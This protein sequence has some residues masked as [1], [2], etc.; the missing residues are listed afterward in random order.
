MIK[1]YLKIFLTDRLKINI[2][3][4][5]ALWD[6][7]SSWNLFPLSYHFSCLCH[8]RMKLYSGRWTNWW[9]IVQLLTETDLLTIHKTLIVPKRK[10][11]AFEKLLTHIIPHYCI[12]FTGN[13]WNVAKVFLRKNA[14]PQKRTNIK[15]LIELWLHDGQISIVISMANT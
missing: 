13:H 11:H 6:V 7:S 2:A 5:C 15:K 14:V 12:I 1:I 4:S 10:Y 3:I 8:L 9:V